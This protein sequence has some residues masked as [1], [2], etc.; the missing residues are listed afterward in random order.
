M[1]CNPSGRQTSHLSILNQELEVSSGSS[2]GCAPAL[3]RPNLPR[4][5]PAPLVASSF[6]WW[7]TRDGTCRRSC[8]GASFITFSGQRG[9]KSPEVMVMGRGSS[10]AAPQGQGHR[11]STGMSPG[12]PKPIPSPSGMGTSA[13]ATSQLCHMSPCHA[14]TVPKAADSTNGRGSGVGE[15]PLP[16]RAEAEPR[17]V[18]CWRARLPLTWPRPSHYSELLIGTIRAGKWPGKA[19]G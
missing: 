15:Q 4:G 18:G 2:E 1:M 16:G 11:A 5:L 9:R 7:P 10:P 14:Q 12:P 3:H 13:P 17:W 6:L 19:Y 8:S